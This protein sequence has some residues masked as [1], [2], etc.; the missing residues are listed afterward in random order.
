MGINFNTQTITRRGLVACYDASNP[1]SYSPNVHPY[2]TD[3]Y[4]WAP[5]GAR[6][7][8]SR[9]TTTRSPVGRSPLKMVVT[10]NDPYTSTYNSTS[11]NLASTYDGENWV[12]SVWVKASTPTEG[13]IFIF[14]A[15]QSDGGYNNAPATT[16]NITTDWKRF[17]YT[18]PM[19][20]GATTNSIQVRLDGPDSGFGTDGITRPTI[21]WDGIQ[22]ERGT[23]ATDFN[24]NTNVNG[25]KIYDLSSYGVTGTFYNYGYAVPTSTSGP[26]YM[27]FNG[28][29]QYVGLGRSYVDSGEI[30]TGDR[31]YSLEAWIYL[32]AN[33]TG[34]VG[35]G[36]VSIL[37]NADGN[38]VGLQIANDGTKN[39]IN[40]GYRSTNNFGGGSTILL[41]TWYH[42]LCT[43][44]IGGPSTIYVNG[45]V[46]DT[47]GDTSL[48]VNTTSQE[49]QIGYAATRVGYITGRISTVRIYNS[50]LTVSEVYQNFTASRAKYGV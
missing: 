43:R 38:G 32:T 28:T 45:V 47:L 10:S 25:N 31:E 2:P 50:C 8:L 36:A 40:F 46:T 11:F 49:I 48:S 9:D 29:S 18:V 17:T 14:S 30:K 13:Q 23:V 19:S 37:G 6:C 22:V 3:M 27:V 20:G 39:Y 42:V 44:A 4:S 33:A 35:T 41:N 24:P 34:L 21:W 15:R 12:V 7:T 5:T 16:I 1:R 26:G